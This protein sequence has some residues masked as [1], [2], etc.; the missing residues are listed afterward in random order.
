M[1][2]KK[3][4][5]ETFPIKK[6]M[7]EKKKEGDLPHG[8]QEVPPPREDHEENLPPGKHQTH[9]TTTTKGAVK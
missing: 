8:R 3:N 1:K 7:K 4:M 9:E 5:K 6:N 2:E